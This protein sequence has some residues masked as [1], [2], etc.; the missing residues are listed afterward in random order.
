LSQLST[1][2]MS[3]LSFLLVLLISVASFAITSSFAPY[4]TFKCVGTLLS[5]ALTLHFLIH[6]PVKRFDSSLS[7]ILLFTYSVIDDSSKYRLEFL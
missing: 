3:R 2:T 1:F 4:P 5:V 7:R 6:D